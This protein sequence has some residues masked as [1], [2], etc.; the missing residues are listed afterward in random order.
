MTNRP[1]SLIRLAG[2]PLSLTLL[3]I[4]AGSVINRV[5]VVELG[6]PVILAGL[7]IAVPLLIS[8]VRIWL[9]HLSDA[10]PLRGRRREPYLILGAILSGGGVALSVALVVQT[11]ALLSTGAALILLGLLLYG[12]GRNLTGNTFQ[13]LLTDRFAAGVPRARAANLY[14]VVKILGLVAGAGLLGLALRPYSNERLVL[15]VA[16]LSALAVL[17]SVLG[18][19]GQEPRTARLREAAEAARAS[20]FW[21]S[22]RTLVWEDP[23]ARLFL[24]VITLTVL[25]TQMQDVLMEPYAGLVLGMDVA[26]TTRLTMFW[27][28]GAL[29]SILLSGLV[30]VRWLGLARL[31]RL[32]IALLLPLL[33]L[34]V[35]AG[36]LQRPLLLQL[37]VLGL[38]LGS[39][40]AAASLLAQAVEFTNARSAGLLLGVWGLGFQLGRAL[41]SVLGAGLVD[42]MNL[43]IGDVPLAAYGAAF[44]AE[45]TLLIGALLVYGRLRTSAARA[46]WE[47]ATL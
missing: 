2:L 16:V 47:P 41:A 12:V 5:M 40:L 39:G 33:V 43:V 8:P 26:A 30:L 31:Y 24:A 25:G 45:G 27:G 35:L 38:G 19:L 18:A 9:G 37:S 28:L 17:L 20:S 13:A 46:L 10:Y 23:Q 7:F 44:A 34:V 4:L 21:R 6:L 3:S 11:P 15:V 1:L 29:A 42:L 36:V 32:G 14:E 22:F